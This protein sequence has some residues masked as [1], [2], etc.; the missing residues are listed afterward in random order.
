M[1]MKLTRILAIGCLL[2]PALATAQAYYRWVDEEGVV[3]FSQQPPLNVANVEQRAVPLTHI[4]AA[5][6]PSATNASET[7]PGDDEE[8]SSGGTGVFGRN[9]A[10]CSQVQQSLATMRSHE[11]INMSME[12]GSILQVH[13][14]SRQAEI[15]RLLA[16]QDYYC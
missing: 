15:S 14:E 8:G 2:L 9:E 11:V 16:L 4:T 6:P 13:G 12:D 10:M 5:P 7:A 3:H 1:N